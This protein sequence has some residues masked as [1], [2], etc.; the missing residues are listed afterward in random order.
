MNF[1]TLVQI[2]V[3]LFIVGLVATIFYEK[4]KTKTNQDVEAEKSRT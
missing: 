3:G 2:A 4:M 1:D